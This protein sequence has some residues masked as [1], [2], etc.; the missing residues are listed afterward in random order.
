MPGKKYFSNKFT[1]GKFLVVL[2]L[3][4]FLVLIILLLLWMF[5][6]SFRAPGTMNTI[7]PNSLQFDNYQRAIKLADERDYPIS[8]MYKNSIITTFFSVGITLII[9]SLAAYAFSKLKFKGSK[10]IFYLILIAMVIPVQIFLIPIFIF[11]KYTGLLNSYVGLI[12]PYIAFGMSLGI[13]IFKGFFDQIPKELSEAAKIDGASE[14][15]TFLRIILPIS[16]PAIS[17]VIIFLF[18]QNWNEFILALV[19]LSKTNLYTVP[20]ALSKFVGEF[21]FPWELYAAT[22]FLTAIPIMIVFF[23]FQNWFIKGLTAG[24]IKG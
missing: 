18:L 24:A 17:T 19:L 1:F 21:Y 14:F 22:V 4:C 9:S 7:I 10:A 20:V 2:Y 3:I 11:S 15:Q 16:K 5:S 13:F 23:I 12:L 6:L 8:Q